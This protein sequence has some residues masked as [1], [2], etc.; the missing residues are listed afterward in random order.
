MACYS[1]TMDS[2]TPARR[3]TLDQVVAYNLR[4]ARQLRDWT[5]NHAAE[6]L[7]PCL[8]ERWSSAVFSAAERSYEGTRV[9]EF[10][11]SH[12][13]A[14]SL[15]FELPITWFYEPPAADVQVHARGSD[16]VISGEDLAKLLGGRDAAMEA[17]QK[18][19]FS[20]A[21]TL[22]TGAPPYDQIA[23][24]I[25]S[26]VLPVDKRI[27]LAELR[28]VYSTSVPAGGSSTPHSHAAHGTTTP[29][30]SPSTR[31]KPNASTPT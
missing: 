15:G 30:S 23:E 20:L 21:V 10:T 3:I 31:L 14:F 8:G 18:I 11:A 7:E 22:A 19:T 24:P 26:D 29:H 4:R 27:A 17:L 1:R 16:R 6:R 28:G 9:R 5:Q 25:S 13:L 2:T 12:V